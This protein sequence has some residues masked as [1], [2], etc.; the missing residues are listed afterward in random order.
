MAEHRIAMPAYFT[1]AYNYQRVEYVDKGKALIH[2]VLQ[3]RSSQTSNE[4]DTITSSL[5]GYTNDKRLREGWMV[6]GRYV[7]K[8]VIPHRTVTVLYLEEVEDGR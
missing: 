5:V 6:D 2:I 7:V 1:D 8:S 3:D 4:L